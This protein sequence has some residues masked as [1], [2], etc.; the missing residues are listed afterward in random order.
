M[1]LDS[2]QDAKQYKRYVEI[3]KEGT[4]K[5][6]TVAEESINLIWSDES[7]VFSNDSQHPLSAAEQ[8][9]TN[10]DNQQLISGKPEKRPIPNLLPIKKMENAHVENLPIRKPFQDIPILKQKFNSYCDEVP[11][12]ATHPYEYAEYLRIKVGRALADATNW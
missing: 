1:Q 9:N 8:L 2:Q 4:C 3:E 6:S 11:N 7:S 10:G 5:G 12:I